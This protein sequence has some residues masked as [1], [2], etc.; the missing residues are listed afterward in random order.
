MKPRLLTAL[1]PHSMI[2]FTL[3]VVLFLFSQRG[4]TQAVD[5]FSKDTLQYYSSESLLSDVLDDLR[6]EKPDPNQ[7]SEA[8][9]LINAIIKVS[10][11]IFSDTLQN[12]GQNFDVTLGSLLPELN[13]TINENSQGRPSLSQENN[14]T[15]SSKKSGSR[16]LKGSGGVNSIRVDDA[17]DAPMN[18]YSAAELVQEV[19]VTG[20]LTASNITFSGNESVQIGYFNKGNSDFPL[21]EG[22]VLSTGNVADAEGDNTATNITTE[23]GTGGDTELQNIATGTVQDASVLEFDFVPAGNTVTFSYIFASEEYPEW[24]CSQYN[25]VFGF[26]VTSLENDG[27]GYNNQNVAQLPAGLGNVSINNVHGPGRGDGSLSYSYDQTLTNPFGCSGVSTSTVFSENFSN[28]FSQWTFNPSQGNWYISSSKA[29]FDNRTPAR[30][31]NYSYAMESIS[32]NTTPNVSTELSYNLQLN[33]DEYNS[34]EFMEV[35]VWDGSSWNSVALYT[36][37]S[38]Y[39][40][41]YQI[42]ISAYVTSSQIKVRFHAYGDDSDD[43]DYWYVDNVEVVQSIVSGVNE[44]DYYSFDTSCSA[45]NPDYYVDQSSYVYTRGTGDCIES[46]RGFPPYTLYK[47]IEADGRTVKLTATF[48]AV[49][50][51]TYHIKLAVGDVADRKYDS[52][53]SG[54]K[55]FPPKW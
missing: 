6:D 28:G 9:A 4:Y 1:K 19:L 31:F 35:E 18:S 5:S 49:P 11:G 13:L 42:D 21:S 54:R 33:D 55:L 48:T 51:S 2:I 14:R 27:I 30:R 32:I 46:V 36:N 40:N 17:V 24:S 43:I 38:N 50:C 10:P 29:R 41:S 53:F 15:G 23:V 20:C 37:N 25:D 39:N 45:S 44:T 26:F 52:C 3:S 7:K 16:S 12:S 22:I 8:E 47:N 34:Q